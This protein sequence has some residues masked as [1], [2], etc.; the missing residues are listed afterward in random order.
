M[1]FGSEKGAGGSPSPVYSVSQPL[2]DISSLPLFT[3]HQLG[4]RRKPEIP[5]RSK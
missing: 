4:L 1:R 5:Q 3:P 2:A